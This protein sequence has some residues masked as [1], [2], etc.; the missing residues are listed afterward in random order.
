VSP[1]GGINLLYVPKSMY[2][3][4]VLTITLMEELFY[5]TRTIKHVTSVHSDFS[6]SR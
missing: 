3:H 5:L 1:R 6:V 4:P 2:D